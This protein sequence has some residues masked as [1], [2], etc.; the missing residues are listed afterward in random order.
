MPIRQIL[1]QLQNL[2]KNLSV[3]KRIT[4]LILAV[5]C[6]SGFIFLMSW[7]GRPEFHPLYSNLDSQD[8]GI[9]L[10]RLKDQKI[11]YQISSNGSTILIP[12]EHI[13]ETRMALASEGLP[14][15]GSIG[16]ELFDNTKFGMSEFAQN[17]NYQRALQGEL[18]RTING[19]P[20]VD[21]SRVHIV[22]P[23]KS[24]F[25]NEEH[26]SSAS[27]V[28]NLHHGKWLTQNQVQGIVHLVSSSVS[29]LAPDHVTVVDS[30]GRL[31]AGLKDDSG[32]GTLSSDQLDYQ[33][34]VERKLE[35]RVL[36]ML[37]EAL[38]ANR[39]IV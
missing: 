15:G 23:E 8:A 36:K 19:F 13:Y 34:K 39:A 24:L 2:L 18:A 38:G 31:L 22:M 32:L 33:A 29:R 3:G 30:S 26:S 21:S 16:F 25:I 9:I 28:L 37:E 17:V 1:V 7:A 5:S 4:I 6:I 11:P 10:N 27:V 12:Q 14:Q 35:S 20:E